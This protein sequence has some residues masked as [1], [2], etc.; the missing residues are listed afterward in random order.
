MKL[1]ILIPVK[2]FA[3]AKQRLSSVLSPEEREALAEAMFRDVLDQAVSSRAVAAIF[4]VTAD[5]KAAQLA[6]AQGAEWI[7]EESEQGETEAVNLALTELKRRGVPSVLI[8]P[9]D[10]PLVRS[11]DLEVVLERAES[12]GVAPGFGLMVPSRDHDG[13]NA[14][15]LSPPDLI[16]PRFGKNSF[17]HHLS[18]LAA[19]GVPYTI[20]EN[21]NLGLDI[22][23]ADDLGSLISHDVGGKT[24][25]KLIGFPWVRSHSGAL[26]G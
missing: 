3:S 14:L 23:G 10:I 24:R 9:A 13:T 6:S 1:S 25:E 2:T 8:I 18:C 20:I 7:R 16:S 26:G 19:R 15:L 4:V 12:S 21:E 22:D 11:S 5:L 17:P